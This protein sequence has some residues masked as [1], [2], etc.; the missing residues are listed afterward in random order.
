[1]FK[2]VGVS[3]VRDTLAGLL[4][5]LVNQKQFLIAPVLAIVSLMML[6]R[7]R[8]GDFDIV[9][10]AAMSTYA[11][12][13]R[14]GHVIF[15]LAIGAGAVIA[16]AQIDMSSIGVATFSS[17]LYA[18]TLTYVQKPNLLHLW[19]AAIPSCLFGMASGYLTGY[20]FNKF[21]VPILIYTWAVGSI[22]GL[23]SI[24]LTSLVS[25]ACKTCRSDVSGVPLN[26]S[27]PDE[28]WSFGNTGFFLIIALQ[29]I[30]VMFLVNSNMA[31][32][33][34]SIG[35]SETSAQYLGVDKK[36]VYY[37]VFVFNSLMASIA[38]VVHTYFINQ[39]ATRDLVGN[40]LVPIAIAVLGGTGLAGGY[41]VLPSVI[42]AALFWACI[43]AIGPLVIMEFPA[44]GVAGEIGQLLFFSVFV[45]V[46]V[47]FG[48]SLMPPVAKIYAK[49]IN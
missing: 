12:L 14:D 5:S 19:L 25:K 16:T 31:I 42:C 45:V 11:D 33:A 18:T 17:V 49:V 32:R 2:F 9:G 21:R 23:L 36:K 46:S 8:V 7:L 47:A 24:F 43:K 22:Y 40:E 37:S 35:A 48:K 26:Y 3:F 38:G 10:D 44:L 20:L 41:L 1:M 28:F 6:L 30:S 4:S 39:A 29:L 13:I 15:L 27:I 34:C